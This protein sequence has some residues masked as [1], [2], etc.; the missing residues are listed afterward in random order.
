MS[1]LGLTVRR[2]LFRKTICDF[3]NE[4]TDELYPVHDNVS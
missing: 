2:G 1:T 4:K 3:F